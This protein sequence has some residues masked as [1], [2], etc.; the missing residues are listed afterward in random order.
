MWKMLGITVSMLALV[1]A[2]CDGDDERPEDVQAFCAAFQQQTL[3]TGGFADRETVTDALAFFE[4]LDR[5][6][7]AEIETELATLTAGL[8]VIVEAFEDFEGAEGA[9]ALDAVEQAA[10][11]SLDELAQAAATVEEFAAENCEDVDVVE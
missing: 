1:L 3:V 8:E 4:S 6:A 5:Q 11:V 7:P 2:G 9:E 10:D